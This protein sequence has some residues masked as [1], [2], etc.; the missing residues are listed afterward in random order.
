MILFLKIKEKM[1]KSL[2][3][4]CNIQMLKVPVLVVCNAVKVMWQLVLVVCVIILVLRL[5][6]V[7]VLMC[8]PKT[9][10]TNLK[11]ATYVKRL[12]FWILKLGLRPLVLLLV[13]GLSIQVILIGSTYLEQEA[14]A[15]PV[16]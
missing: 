13:P 11:M 8:Q 12:L 9:L 16:I 5:L 2:F 15:L 4:R 1:V 7:L 6:L 3:S 10:W 14:L